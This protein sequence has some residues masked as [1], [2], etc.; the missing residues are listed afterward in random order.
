MKVF[1]CDDGYNYYLPDKHCA[2]CAN[3]TDIFWDYTHGPYMFFCA[4][5][6]TVNNDTCDCFVPE[7]T[8]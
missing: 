3:C 1:E 2:F 7:D 6:M 8:K 5:G 4:I